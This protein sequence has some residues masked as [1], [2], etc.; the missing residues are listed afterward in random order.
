MATRG[1]EGRARPKRINHQICL[2]SQSN[3]RP[4]RSC[5]SW[6]MA[7]RSSFPLPSST[8][9]RILDDLAPTA[10]EHTLAAGPPAR[11]QQRSGAST[12]APPPGARI[13]TRSRA[14]RPNYCPGTAYTP[15]AV[16]A[17]RER[18]SSFDAS[19]VGHFRRLRKADISC[20]SCCA[21]SAVFAHR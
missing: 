5:S 2:H 15:S 18:V 11:P 14:G 9:H 6:S 21:R 8:R 16:P 4:P 17:G 13:P 3:E 10:V 12:D 19:P 7:C 1:L 20:Q